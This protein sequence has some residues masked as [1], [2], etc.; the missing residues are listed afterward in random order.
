MADKTTNNMGKLSVTDQKNALIEAMQQR[1]EE[2]S[3]LTTQEILNSAGVSN[4]RVNQAMID[5]KNLAQDFMSKN[6]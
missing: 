1:I 6:S 3:T 4:H 5:P 2:K